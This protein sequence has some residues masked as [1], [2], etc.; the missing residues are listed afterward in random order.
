MK[1]QELKDLVKECINEESSKLTE[2]LAQTLKKGQVYNWSGGATST[3]PITYIGPR[4]EN[5]EI[6]VGSSIGKGYIFQWEDGHYLELG[7]ITIQANI[8]PE[9]IDEQ[10]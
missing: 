9:E 6:Q 5:P 10:V 8:G 3:M 7:P 1:A 4:R 2:T